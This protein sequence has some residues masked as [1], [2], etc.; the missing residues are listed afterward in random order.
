MVANSTGE[1]RNCA[2]RLGAWVVRNLPA[3]LMAVGAIVGL[4]GLLDPIDMR[5]STQRA[6]A[7]LGSI[8]A[9]VGVGVLI[10]RRQGADAWRSPVLAVVVLA[11]ALIVLGM[12]GGMGG[13][14]TY[15]R[16]TT[17]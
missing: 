6:M 10:V 9:A 12:M 4:F 7:G 13:T 16:G 5:A 3:A 8:G 1:L 11:I 15:V 2:L 17:R 14:S